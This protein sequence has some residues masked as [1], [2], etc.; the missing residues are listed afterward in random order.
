MNE[1]QEKLEA[2][3]AKIEKLRRLA[4]GSEGPESVSAAAMADKLEQQANEL[5][6][7]GE[8]KRASRSRSRSRARAAAEQQTMRPPRAPRQPRKETVLPCSYDDTPVVQGTV[9]TPITHRYFQIAEHSA[10]WSGVLLH[11]DRKWFAP[12]AVFYGPPDR[13]EKAW[14]RFQRICKIYDRKEE[15]W[16]H[17][18]EIYPTDTDRDQYAHGFLSGLDEHEAK[19]EQTAK[20]QEREDSLRRCDLAYRRGDGR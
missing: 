1:E 19:K 14:S 16:A 2:L 20:R 13:C 18:Q 3:R 12:Y 5:E 7:A 6:K 4:D 17:D 15:K 11:M 8:E 9:I 10:R